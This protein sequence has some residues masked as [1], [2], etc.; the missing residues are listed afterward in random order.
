MITLK[1]WM[2][3]CNYRITE[4]GD[5]TPSNARIYSLDSWNGDQNGHSLMIGFDP[6]TQEVYTVEVHDYKNDRSYRLVNPQFKE[7]FTDNEAYDGVEFTDL[8]VDDDFIEKATAIVN[9]EEYDTGIL[10]PLNFTDEELL[11]IFKLAHEADMS[12]N[13]YVNMALRNLVDT[14]K[15][16]NE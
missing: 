4:G 6:K 8:E 3:I 1:Q 13:D 9:G 2:E 11:P 15:K 7:H 14:L 10:V 16:E 12:F 5:Y